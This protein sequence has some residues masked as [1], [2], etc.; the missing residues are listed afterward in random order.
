M[1][2]SVEDLTSQVSSNVLDNYELV[3]QNYTKGI[4]ISQCTLGGAHHFSVWEF[5]GYEPYQIFYDHFMADQNCIH[6][7]VYNL[8]QS[9]NEC[10]DECVHW[11]EFLRARIVLNKPV[12]ESSNSRNGS[13]HSNDQQQQQDSNSM[14]SMDGEK[15]GYV[16]V[17]FIGTHA[18][19]DKSCVKNE[20]GLFTSEKAEELQNM[21]GEYYANDDVFDLNEP[22]FV[23]DARAAWVSDIKLL[24]NRLVKLKQEVSERLPRCTMF[25]N[26]TL[27]HLQNFRKNNFAGI[28]VNNQQSTS[29]TSPLVKKIFLA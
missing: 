11:V 14:K 20:D 5:S 7:I 2:L 1:K 15:R 18:D 25:L 8:N 12:F 23:L 17:L 10:F 22:H 9:L 26:R 4:E 24:I 6:M 27:F 3:H 13:I 28:A 21:L 19:L 29:S 16:R